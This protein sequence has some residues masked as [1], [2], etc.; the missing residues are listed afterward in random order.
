MPSWDWDEAAARDGWVDQSSPNTDNNDATVG[1]QGYDYANFGEIT[2]DPVACY[3]LHE[4]SGTTAHDVAGTNDGTHSGPMLG[5]A[6][7]LG[8]TAPDWDGIDD[9]MGVPHDDLLSLSSGTIQAWAE[10]DVI[11]SDF[12]E[13]VIKGDSQTRNY[14]IVCTSGTNGLRL[15]FTSGA[16]NYNELQVD[17]ANINTDEWNLITGTIN[18]VGGDTELEL[19]V[20]GS[21][22]DSATI[23]GST[24]NA[25]TFDLSVGNRPAE[26]EPF[27]GRLS[28][29]RLYDQVLTQSQIQTLYDVVR[30]PGDWLG[31]GKLL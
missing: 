15:G 4:D 28:D 27:D 7:I 31:Q 16:Q 11:D 14:Y 8:T 10:P 18:V 24:P 17:A 25:N 5:Q 13:Y 12:R 9:R 21:S 29:V 20:D 19:F 22:I 3:P 6:G 2:P 30:S 1:K 26:D 23:S